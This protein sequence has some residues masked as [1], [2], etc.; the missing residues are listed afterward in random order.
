MTMPIWTNDGSGWQ[1]LATT[2]FPNETALH[3]LVEQAPQI[4]PLAGSPRLIIVGREVLLGNGYADLIAV[5]PTGRLA[6][7]EVKLV[8]NAEARRAIVAQVLTYAAYLDGLDPTVLERDIL[9]PHLRDRG[10]ADLAG[11]VAAND[12]MGAFDAATF[13]EGLAGSLAVGRFRLVLVLDDASEELIRLIGHLE[14]VTA[15]RLLIDLATVASYR[16]GGSEVIVPQRVEAERRPGEPHPTTAVPSDGT[17]RLVEGV[18]DFDASIAAVREEQRPAL[19]RLRD[20]A[21]TLQREGLIRLQTYHMRGQNRLSLLP[22]LVDE[23]VG[24]VTIYNYNGASS[25]Q[26]FRRVFERR[27][28][29]ALA[30]VEGLI[31]PETLGQGTTVRNV[32]DQL[33]GALAD[34]YREAIE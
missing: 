9:A 11:A 14:A 16:I 32:T 34:A 33:L 22:R 7:I 29:N 26:V 12:Q 13:A 1:L 18:E 31:A 4:L 5:E 28:P 6:I 25:L 30:N 17:G 15:D 27:S 2:G 3:T 8:R 10:Y 20:W 21:V 23:G 19:Q 24:L